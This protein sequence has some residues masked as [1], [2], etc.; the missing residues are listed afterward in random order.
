MILN[1]DKKEIDFALVKQ[2]EI[3]QMIEVKTSDKTISKTLYD[4]HK[5]YNFPAIQIVGDLRQERVYGDIQV[6]KMLPFLSDLML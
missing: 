5:K 6:V 1:S 3:E 2:G 4:F